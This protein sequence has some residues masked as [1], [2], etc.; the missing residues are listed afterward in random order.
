[1][2]SSPSAFRRKKIFSRKKSNNAVVYCNSSIPRFQDA[3]GHEFATR[4]SN[5]YTIGKGTKPWV[6]LPKGKGIKLT[7]IE[8]AMK[9]QAATQAAA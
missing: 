4:L 2:T 1:M 8:E 3:T 7:I 9:R 6:P 5:V